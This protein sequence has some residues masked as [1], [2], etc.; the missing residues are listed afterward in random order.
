MFKNSVRVCKKTCLHDSDRAVN[1]MSGNYPYLYWESY[2][3]HK[4]KMKVIDSESRWYVLLT[5]G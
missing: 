4:Y 1:S 2:E 3:T 5:L